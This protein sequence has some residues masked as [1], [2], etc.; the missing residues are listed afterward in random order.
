MRGSS[1][2]K[3]FRSREWWLGAYLS[4]FAALI[5]V[6]LLSVMSSTHSGQSILEQ[7]A[8][9]IMAVFVLFCGPVVAAYAAAAFLF[10][11]RRGS[12]R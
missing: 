12:S 10:S 1:A 6:L 7:P 9:R 3:W 5:W 2:K 8:S 4:L 11:G